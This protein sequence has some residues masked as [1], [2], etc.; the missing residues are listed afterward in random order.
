MLK[1][2][3]AAVLLLAPMPRFNSIVTGGQTVFT[4]RDRTTA[5]T[6]QLAIA[7]ERRRFWRRALATA[8]L[9]CG[10]GSRCRLR[11]LRN[12]RRTLLRAI[13]AL[14]T[15]EVFRRESAN[16][17]A[18]ASM[19]SGARQAWPYARYSTLFGNH[20]RKRLPARHRARPCASRTQACRIAQLA[21]SIREYARRLAD[22]GENASPALVG[23]DTAFPGSVIVLQ[24][25]APSPAIVKTY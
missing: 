20:Y 1:T 22:S 7:N 14:Q 12:G 4:V 23:I 17:L 13:Q 9:L 11:S 24:W 6:P 3:I 25:A 18:A 19:R 5:L 8:T 15:A 10:N 21:R 16:A 2:A